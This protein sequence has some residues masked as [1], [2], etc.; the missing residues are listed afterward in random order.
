M[1][2]LRQ[3]LCF[4]Y[5]LEAYTGRQGHCTGHPLCG[6]EIIFYQ[7]NG[8]GSYS[9]LKSKVGIGAVRRQVLMGGSPMKITPFT[10]AKKVTNAILYTT[11]ALEK[12]E[13]VAILE[14]KEKMV[15][16]YRQYILYRKEVIHWS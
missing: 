10:L 14:I 16:S 12:H 9:C 4:H 2:S 5:P 7:K 13:I 8:R 3:N 6:C 11:N 1:T 15:V